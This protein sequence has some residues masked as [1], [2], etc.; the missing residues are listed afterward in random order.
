MDNGDFWKGVAIGALA[1]GVIGA[2]IALLYAPK[3]GAETRAALKEKLRD[4]KGKASEFGE[5]VTTAVKGNKGE[6]GA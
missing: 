2:S 3:S 5:C 1:G 6:E 4:I